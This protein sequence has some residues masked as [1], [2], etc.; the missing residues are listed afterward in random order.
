MSRRAREYYGA[1]KK[2]MHSKLK[3]TQDQEGFSNKSHCSW[4]P[5]DR[6]AGEAKLMW[7]CVRVFWRKAHLL[8]QGDGKVQGPKP[9]GSMV[10]G[11][12][13]TREELHMPGQRRERAGEASTWLLLAP[14][15]RLDFY[16]TNPTPKKD[17]THRWEP[18]REHREYDPDSQAPTTW[19]LPT[20]PG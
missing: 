10:L 3:E 6:K 2:G 12:H 9:R 19:P 16:P 11:H 7:V 1:H 14:S 5:E 20:V 15:Q 4:N 18:L 13:Q 17:N 8:S